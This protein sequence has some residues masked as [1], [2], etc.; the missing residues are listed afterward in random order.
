[1]NKIL[2]TLG[3]LLGIASYAQQGGV[4]VHLPTLVNCVA[5]CANVEVVVGS[6]KDPNKVAKSAPS[7]ACSLLA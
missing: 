5:S 6:R 7:Q 2:V 4:S 3:V 1:M